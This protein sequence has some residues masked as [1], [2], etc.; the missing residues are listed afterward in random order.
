MPGRDPT[1]IIRL[2]TGRDG[3]PI[4]S[5]HGDLVR[6]IDLLGLAGG[7]LGALG[8]FAAAL[9]LGEERCDPGAVDE[10]AGAEEGGEEEEVE[11]YAACRGGV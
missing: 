3:G 9:F 1:L 10:V 8:A 11:E 7:F 2:R 5:N 6:G 4:G